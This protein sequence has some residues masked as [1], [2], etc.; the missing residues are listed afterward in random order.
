MF[1]LLSC[2]GVKELCCTLDDGEGE[3]RGTLRGRQ[4]SELIL[5]HYR[6]SELSQLK[7]SINDASTADE[8]L[9]EGVITQSQLPRML[10]SIA[11][12]QNNRENKAST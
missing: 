10:I 2:Q 5:C 8:E 6:T 7:I 3:G 4:R 1:L 9:Q 12:L 11:G